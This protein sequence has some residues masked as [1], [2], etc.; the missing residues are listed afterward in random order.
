VELNFQRL[1]YIIEVASNATLE[2]RNLNLTDIATI[3]DGARRSFKEH[4]FAKGMPLWPSITAQPN[5]T[6]RLVNVTYYFRAKTVLHTRDCSNAT[7]LPEVAN[8]RP[9]PLPCR[10]VCSNVLP[11]RG[12]RIL[13]GP[14]PLWSGRRPPLW[15]RFFNGVL[16]CLKAVESNHLRR[17][18]SSMDSTSTMC[19]RDL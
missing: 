17:S 15:S 13:R 11:P 6:I 7:A 8:V 18:R 16:R 12:E 3:H 2:L 10:R 9:W 19:Q 4:F 14:P 1:P 5:G